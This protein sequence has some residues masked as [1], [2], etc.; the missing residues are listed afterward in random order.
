[1]IKLRVSDFKQF[2]YCPRVVFYNYVMPVEKATTFKMEYGKIAEDGI[3]K[4]ESRRKLK[5]YG[6]SEGVRQFHLQLYS[7]NLELSGKV[8]LLIKTTESYYPVDFKY[9]A[10]QPHENHLY[11]ILGYAIILEDIYNCRVDRGFIYLIPKEDAVVFNLTDELKVKAKN[12]L[13]DIRE[14]ISLQQMPPPAKSK[15]KCLDCE[16][17]N[18]CGDIFT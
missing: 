12:M 17:R 15:N 11:Q 18:F 5:R 13:G 8:D 16:Y 4:L 6:L 9:T 10:S 14:M 3:D 7:K 1:M 2:I